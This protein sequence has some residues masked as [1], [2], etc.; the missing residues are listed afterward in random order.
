MVTCCFFI[1]LYGFIFGEKHCYYLYL[2]VARSPV[3][4]GH[5]HH[6]WMFGPPLSLFLRMFRP[7][8]RRTPYSSSSS[9]GAEVAEP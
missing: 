4:D 8:L 6:H 5:V 7:A 9:P 3:F 2:V 1:I